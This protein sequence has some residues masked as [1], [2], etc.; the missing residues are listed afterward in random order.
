MPTPTL[1]TLIT[2]NGSNGKGPYGSLIADATGDLFGT[3]WNGGSSG[4][5]NVFEIKYVGGVFASTPTE[6]VGFNGFN[7]AYPLGSLL[8]DANGNLFG[9]VST[10]G[11]DGAGAVVEIANTAGVFASTPTILA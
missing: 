4:S 6:L 9:T 2:F 3:T 5:G 1:T 11:V 8:A 10:G 7:G